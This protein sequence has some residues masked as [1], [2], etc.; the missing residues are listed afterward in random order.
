MSNQQYRTK[1]NN[2]QVRYRLGKWIKT[3]RVQTAL[4]TSLAIWGG[5]I[6]VSPLTFES[7]V[8]LGFIGLQY[9][10]FGFTMNEVEDYKYDASI[11]NGSEHPI[12]KGEVHAGLARYV[13]WIAF[14]LSI[15][16]SV[17]SGYSIYGSIVLM[18]AVIP[19][20]MYNKYSKVHWWSNIYLT[21]WAMMMVIAGALH[22]GTP[23]TI[24]YVLA[25]AIGIQIF[26]QVIEGDLKD[27]AGT[28]RSICDVLGVE[29]K[30]TE[31]FINGK[32]DISFSTIESAESVDVIS[33]T[34]KFSALVYGLKSVELVIL[35]YVASIFTSMNMSM[36][37]PYI[38][39]YFIISIVFITSISM[40][41]VYLYQR[42]KVK[43]MSSIHELSAIVLIGASL[44][45]IQHNAGIL[46]AIAPILWY[47]GVNKVIHSGPLNPD[48]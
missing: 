48:I 35:V 43:K 30:S 15:V 46:I 22:A 19:A 1:L 44:Y 20:L 13:S 26:I 4:V 12:A 41:T 31:E 42:D 38:L 37:R 28:E 36:I 14:M 2:L 3:M 39:V 17:L 32:D 5:Y 11:G 6:T 18:L 33:Y 45:P 25:V 40:L 21:I 23:N 27:I 9:H 24:S 47:I 10:I 8:I 16:I 7:A 34:R 29:L